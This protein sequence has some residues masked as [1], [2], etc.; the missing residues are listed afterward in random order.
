[1]NKFYQDAAYF[2][3]NLLT[4]LFT[5]NNIP[6]PIAPAPVTAPIKPTIA[7]TLPAAIISMALLAA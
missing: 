1:M 3:P 2:L 4:S 5:V 7:A 6:A